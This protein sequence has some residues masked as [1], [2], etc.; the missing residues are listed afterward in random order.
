MAALPERG[1]C[2]GGN[3]AFESYTSWP[4]TISEGLFTALSVALGWLGPIVIVLEAGNLPA[5]QRMIKR[6]CVF[7]TDNDAWSARNTGLLSARQTS[8]LGD[9]IVAPQ[10]ALKHSLAKPTDCND[11]FHLAGIDEL[12]T[13][14]A[15]HGSLNAEE[16]CHGSRADRL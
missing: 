13:S 6:A 5:V 3:H 8:K 12:K 16:I 9:S 1:Q 14:S 10:F 7:F 2:V 4:I 11:L 15:R